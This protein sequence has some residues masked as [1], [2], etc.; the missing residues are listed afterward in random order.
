MK[1][2]SYIAWI[3]TRLNFASPRPSG[4]LAVFVLLV[5]ISGLCLYLTATLTA[6]LRI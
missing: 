2:L 6:L 5:A 1:A 4:L 3:W